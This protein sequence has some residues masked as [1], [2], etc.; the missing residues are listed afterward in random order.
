MSTNAS[1]GDS[2][3]LSGKCQKEL[4]IPVIV[5][6]YNQHKVGVDM[7]NQY[8][9]YVD[10]QLI[11]RCRWYLL[12]YRILGTALIDSLIIYRDS[13]ATQ[14]STVEHF[15]FRLSIVHNFLQAGSPSTINASSRIPVS[16][17][18]TRLA[19][20]TQS[21]LPP[22]PTRLVTKHTALP[23]C[24]MVPG[25]YS[26]L[27]MESGVDCFLCRWKRSQGGSGEGMKTGIKCEDCNEALCFTLKW[28]YFYEFHYM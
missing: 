24:Q 22:L 28:N 8:W 16:Q 1:R 20:A 23:L 19:P 11:S 7:A 15:Y 6:A 9:I 26:P 14:E 21:A 25:M 2:T 5:D 27:W 3:F 18:I 13:P 17:E 10:T 4:D 12:F